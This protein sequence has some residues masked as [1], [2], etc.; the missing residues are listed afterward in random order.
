MD[1]LNYKTLLDYVLKIL[2]MAQK[3]KSSKYASL[4]QL[5]IELGQDMPFSGVYEMG[6]YLDARGWAKVIFPLGDIRAQI[7]PA[8][9]VYVEELGEDF[10]ADFQKYVESRKKETGV[11]SLLLKL[12]IE[13]IDPKDNIFILIDHILD[14]IRMKEGNI[15]FVKDLEVVKIEL[16]KTDPDIR[17]IETKLYA[18]ARIPYVSSEIQELRDY[19]IAS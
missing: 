2:V 3:K 12:F 9:I 7:L 15:D 19:L 16:T 11:D 17:L 18:L 1:Q 8:G 13:D 5:V 10:E 6:K 4:V 14:K